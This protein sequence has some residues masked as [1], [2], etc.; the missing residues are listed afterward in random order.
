MNKI[1]VVAVIVY[2]S[3][4]I[5]FSQ[6]KTYSSFSTLGAHFFVNQFRITDSVSKGK[7]KDLIPGLAVS[8]IHEMTS[9]FDFAGTLSASFA[10]FPKKTSGTYGNGENNLLIETDANIRYRLTSALHKV[11]PYIQGGIGIS[12]YGDYYGIY[13]PAGI[14]L[15]VRLLEEAFLLADAQYRLPVTS[16]QDFHIYYSIG[17]A[18]TI[19][20]NKKKKILKKVQFVRRPPVT[21]QVQWDSDGDGIPDSVDACP[22]VKG[23]AKYKGCPIPDSDGDGLNDEE[24]SC[25]HTPGLAKYHGCP[26][27][28]RDGDGVNDEEDQCPDLPGTR[29][30][31]GCPEIKPNLVAIINRAA[32]NIFFETNKYN[33]LPGSFKGLDS[34]VMYLKQDGNLKMSISG[35]TD[36][37]GNPAKNQLLS[38]NRANAVLVYF[39]QKGINANRLS[40]KGYGMHIPIA[41]NKTSAGRAKN[42]RVELSISY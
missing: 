21:R 11:S 30:N 9:H 1:L 25:P 12:G 3:P 35:H 16:T 2:L 20:K 14:G 4:Q 23:L 17:V 41:D 26:I 36:I 8:Y 39:V 37:V 13:I 10:D 33:I 6:Q 24:D 5:I 15:R 42:R 28:D 34:V 18:G 32:K 7:Y 27:P 38:E 40:A 22:F 19:G 31:H 29:A